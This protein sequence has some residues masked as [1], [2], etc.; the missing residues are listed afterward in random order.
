MRR[1]GRVV[2][3]EMLLRQVWKY[4]SI[5]ETKLVN[6][7]NR[8]QVIVSTGCRSSTIMNSLVKRAQ[9]ISLRR[10]SGKWSL[11]YSYE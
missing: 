8:A 1:E 9:P 7:H 3:R 11:T 4:R 10:P 5:P 6:V 2:T